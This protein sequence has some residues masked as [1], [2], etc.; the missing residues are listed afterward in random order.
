M[1]SGI[2]LS[3][4][5]NGNNIIVVNTQFREAVQVLARQD[6]NPCYKISILMYIYLIL[7]MPFLGIV[8]LLYLPMAGTIWLLY[9]TLCK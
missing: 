8:V 7:C 3:S 5:H 4:L 6:I 1:F 2:M 9:L